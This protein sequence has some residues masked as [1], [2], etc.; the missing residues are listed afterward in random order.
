MGPYQTQYINAHIKRSSFGDKLFK[1]DVH[2]EEHLL[3][4]FISGETKILQGDKTYIYQAGDTLFFPG[5]SW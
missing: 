4:W 2:F 1:A 5:T 3:V